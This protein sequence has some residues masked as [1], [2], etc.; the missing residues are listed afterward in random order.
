MIHGIIYGLTSHHSAVRG[1]ISQSTSKLLEVLQGFDTD[2]PSILS[3]CISMYQDG[4]TKTMH[5]E[6]EMI[7]TLCIMDSL[8]IKSCA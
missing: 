7:S 1:S 8:C 5:G 4:L 6:Y 3:F 2:M